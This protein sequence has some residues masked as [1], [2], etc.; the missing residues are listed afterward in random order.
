M[1]DIKKMVIYI[2]SMEMG[3]FKIIEIEKENAEKFE[4]F[5]MEWPLMHVGP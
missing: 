3:H 5:N 1:K 4:G 2:A